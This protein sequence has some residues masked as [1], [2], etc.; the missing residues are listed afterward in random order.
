[1]NTPRVRILGA[2]SDAASERMPAQVQRVRCACV[3]CVL[4]RRVR[5]ALVLLICIILISLFA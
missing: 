1:M 3:E 5:V 2:L 4:M